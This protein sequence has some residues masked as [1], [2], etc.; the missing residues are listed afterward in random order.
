MC[1]SNNTIYC[2]EIINCYYNEMVS[3]KQ[4]CSDIFEMSGEFG[5]APPMSTVQRMRGGFPGNSEQMLSLSPRS[6]EAGA[7]G[8]NMAEY[9]LG[10]APTTM[11]DRNARLLTTANK[12]RYV[13]DF[14][15]CDHRI[16]TVII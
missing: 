11:R 4:Q 14:H 3:T 1:Q 10:G 15:F 16:L 8:V 9:V 2:Y 5:P 7:L 13:S 6:S 12:G